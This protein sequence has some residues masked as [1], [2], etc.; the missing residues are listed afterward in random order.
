[1]GKY[2]QK[3]KLFASLSHYVDRGVELYLKGEPSS[4]ERTADVVMESDGGYMA[5]FVRDNVGTLR[6]IRFDRVTL[7]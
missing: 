4:P 6:E 2:T 1:M 7:G 5:D 3:L